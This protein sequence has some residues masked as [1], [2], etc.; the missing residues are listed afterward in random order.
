MSSLNDLDAD[1]I[2]G[3]HIQCL[4]L[5]RR[6][7]GSGSSYV[8]Q[9]DAWRKE[10]CVPASDGNPPSRLLSLFA[11]VQGLKADI[12]AG[13]TDV[14]HELIREDVFS[15]ILAAAESLLETSRF[16]ASAAVAGTVLREHLRCLCYKH[17][18]P[19]DEADLPGS[20][21]PAMGEALNAG[22]H[23]AG[24]Y[25][26][27]DREQVAGWLETS[28]RVIKA[29]DADFMKNGL[30]MLFSRHRHRPESLE[31]ADFNAS[32]VGSLIEGVRQ[33]IARYPA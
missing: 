2:D 24:A 31:Y 21:D 27:F 15:S 25:G 5:L 11:I 1:A 28:N 22:L 29:Q 10:A 3:F 17:G 26:A 16:E 32:E 13:H 9:A 30:E 33:F 20:V 14:F 23:D 8:H 6:F 4:S 7:S 12:A 19:V 18:L